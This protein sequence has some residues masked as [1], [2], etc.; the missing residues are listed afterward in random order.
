MSAH[1][2][3]EALGELVAACHEARAEG[4]DD[5]IVASLFPLLNASARVAAT[6]ADAVE[7]Q[8]V[9]AL[10]EAAVA[11]ARE[12]LRASLEVAAT[13]AAR[14]AGEVVGDGGEA[15]SDEASEAVAKCCERMA[16]VGLEAP[17]RAALGHAMTTAAKRRSSTATLEVRGGLPPRRASDGDDEPSVHAHATALGNALG[18]CCAVAGVAEAAAA[19]LG[20]DAARALAAAALDVG[21]AAGVDT[22]ER[23]VMMRSVETVAREVH[24]ESFVALDELLDEVGFALQFGHRFERFVEAR[25]GVDGA[26]ATLKHL[27]PSLQLLVGHYVQIEDAYC[28]ACVR[29]ACR[30]VRATLDPDP[31]GDELDYAGDH[32]LDGAEENPDDDAALVAL[33]DAFFVLRRGVDRAIS[34]LSEQAALSQL[35]R[36]L[37]TIS[38]DAPEDISVYGA[39][40]SIASRKRR[41]ETVKTLADALAEAVDEEVHGASP[42]ALTAACGGAFA[43]A[44]HCR[45]L[46]D[47]V[48]AEL[49]ASL[50][51]ALPLLEDFDGAARTYDAL[52]AGALDA[53]FDE[54]SLAAARADYGA[55]L[56]DSTYGRLSDRDA[57]AADPTAAAPLLRDYEARIL[58][59]RCVAGALAALP[60]GG[61]RLAVARRLAA[62]AAD[63]VLGFLADDSAPKLGA[64]GALA[65]RRDAR[66]LMARLGELL[67]PEE[68]L[69]EARA[70]ET[71]RST[72]RPQ[73][74]ALN[75]ALA[76]A[77]LEAPADARTVP[78][79]ASGVSRADLAAVLGRRRDFAAAAVDAALDAAHLAPG[80]GLACFRPQRGRD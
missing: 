36:T 54:P 39:A 28:D 15:R 59:H 38:T 31:E 33:Q 46:R 4:D 35:H 9:G 26:A 34:T 14:G 18:A 62:D 6:S 44:S 41:D 73:F 58:G 5:A 10:V 75:V 55:S 23:F 52:A 21:A 76:L 20:D 1:C 80:D 67:P 40:A 43:C 8:T 12:R 53:L 42:A 57:A 65:L 69:D 7:V 25:L 16:L 72:L 37:T 22:L 29:V 78:L 56:R 32:P 24:E 74:A 11:G 13:V 30:D 61:P 64:F 77:T 66:A 48:V 45:S 3:M 17:A 2:D 49:A 79:R 19:S 63:A 51:A 71:F 60:T 27:S 70:G 50:P 47:D 68:S